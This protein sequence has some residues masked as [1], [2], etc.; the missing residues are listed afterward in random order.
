[1]TLNDAAVAVRQIPQFEREKIIVPYECRAKSCAEP[2]KKHS[3]SMITTERL[4]GR[5]I[6][7]TDWFAE[8]LLEIKSNPAF[9]QMFWFAQDLPVAHGGRK[10]HRDRIKFPI[11][12]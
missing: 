4:H 11:L 10:S 6:D 5:I 12:H 1:M 7:D 8:R 3:A 2:Q 9:A